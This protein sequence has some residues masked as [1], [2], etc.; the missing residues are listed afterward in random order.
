MDNYSEA[1]LC[2]E[3]IM[4]EEPQKYEAIGQVALCLTKLTDMK[5]QTRCINALYLI[6]PIARG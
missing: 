1:L 4:N 6:S 2:F 3:C 5:K